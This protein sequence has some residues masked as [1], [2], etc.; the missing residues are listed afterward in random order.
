MSNKTSDTRSKTVAPTTLQS[1]NKALNSA[2]SNE[3]DLLNS[4]EY[5]DKIE[6]DLN[7][8]VDSDIE[9]LVEGMTEL[10]KMSKVSYFRYHT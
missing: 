10:V 1:F 8:K 3:T 4:D 6:E 2:A 5:L 7:K 9:I